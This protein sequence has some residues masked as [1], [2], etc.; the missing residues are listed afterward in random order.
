MNDLNEKIKDLEK[1]IESMIEKEKSFQKKMNRFLKYSFSG[2]FVFGSLLAFAQITSLHIFNDGEIISAQKINENFSFLDNKISSIAAGGSANYT[3]SSYTEINPI[4]SDNGSMY[5]VSDDVLKVNLPNLSLVPVGYTLRFGLSS[6]FSQIQLFRDGTDLFSGSA[7][8]SDLMVLEKVSNNSGFFEL[9]S[10]GDEWFISLQSSIN[11]NTF[12]SSLFADFGCT[13]DGIGNGNCYTN[14]SATS[15]GK[16]I[17]QN[18]YMLYSANWYSASSNF[19]LL[20]DLNSLVGDEFTKSYSLTS[21]TIIQDSGIVLAYKS[22]MTTYYASFYNWQS[23]YYP[24]SVISDSFLNDDIS[25]LTATN[26]LSGGSSCQHDYGK[27]WRH[28]QASE[29]TPSIAS[30]IGESFWTGSTLSTG[31]ANYF[32]NIGNSYETTNMSSVNMYI[33]VCVYD[34]T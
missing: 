25:T 23:S 4:S 30:T 19:Y 3:F 13:S 18:R 7:A 21:G 32:D 12:D 2:F 34:P 5:L 26:I 11:Y 6:N 24:P 22:G 33:K 29:V 27:N 28:I 20:N 17:V 8:I 31:S 10:I 9:M 15:V 1:K 16:A 14:T